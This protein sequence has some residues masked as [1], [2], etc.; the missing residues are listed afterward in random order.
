MSKSKTL[1]RLSSVLLVVLLSLFT[2]FI[3]LAETEANTSSIDVNID[4]TVFSP[5]SVRL[6][7][8][9]Y[10][11][12]KNVINQEHLQQCY[13]DSN[14]PLFNSY[15][16]TITP[17]VPM[18]LTLV[19]TGSWCD[20]RYTWSSAIY[21]KPIAN[22]K[23]DMSEL[24]VN[25]VNSDFYAANGLYY[26]FGCKS[27][28]TNNGRNHVHIVTGAN[29]ND[30]LGPLQVL[31]RYVEQQQGIVYSCGAVVTD[32]MSWQD[33]LNYFFHN[34]SEKFASTKAWNK[35]HEIQNTYE[36]VALMAVGHNTG[37]S[38][39]SASGPSGT[40]GS[41]WY[42]AKSVYDYCSALT[43]DSSLQVLHSY[44]DSW[45]ADIVSKA[46][47]GEQFRLA[48]QISNTGGEVQSLMQQMGINITD[49]ASSLG[50]KQTYPILAVL[51]YM[52]LEKLYTSGNMQ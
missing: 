3:S 46:S 23:V 20:T 26:Y 18:A 45:Y 35:N 8:E 1:Y 42:N 12:S 37:T 5:V 33:N 29:D 31:R 14:T 24:S 11:M 17:L 27:N 16:R 15:K 21:S 2:T 25:R 39:M 7:T 13:G 40:A 9:I 52:S 41:K 38:F 44:V 6:N 22:A 4:S 30:S 32:L 50:H 47:A 49:Y 28:C 10:N 43:S 34:Q 19:E 36:L 51:N 48:G